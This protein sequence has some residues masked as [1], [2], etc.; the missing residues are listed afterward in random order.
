MEI[1][2][3]IP[4]S[5]G[6]AICQAAV[7][8]AED[9]HVP[10]RVV[11][12]RQLTQQHARLDRAL[13]AASTELETL[14]DTVSDELGAETAAIFGFHMGV[15]H[16]AALIKQVH[17]LIDAEAVTAEFSLATVLRKYAQIFLGM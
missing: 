7:L 16:D 9:I 3:G 15:L 8:D 1:K 11:P 17:D 10:R 13:T 2:K 6:V 12:R 4:V 14:R 5:P